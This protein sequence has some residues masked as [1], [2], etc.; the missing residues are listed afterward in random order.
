MRQRHAMHPAALAHMRATQADLRELR[1]LQLLASSYAA[2]QRR[3]FAAAGP[4]ELPP[5]R[6][7]PN[8]KAQMASLDH[9]P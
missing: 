1:H 2:A 8:P 5:V 4:A 7:A 6:A 3:L 9:F